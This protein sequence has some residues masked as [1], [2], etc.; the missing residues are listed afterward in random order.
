MAAQKRLSEQQQVSL[1][2]AERRREQEVA[3]KSRV[4]EDGLR[5]DERTLTSELAAEEARKVSKD[6]LLAEAA[7]V[8]GDEVELLKQEGGAGQLS[9]LTRENASPR[10]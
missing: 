3:R 6:V 4:E 2:E 5:A 1:N 10:P 7:K 9:A 8:L